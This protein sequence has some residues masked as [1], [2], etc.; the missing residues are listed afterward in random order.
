MF[1]SL[2][3]PAALVSGVIAFVL[4]VIGLMLVEF[5]LFELGAN[6]TLDILV[7]SILRFTIFGINC[8]L[9]IPALIGVVVAV[10]V[11]NHWPRRSGA[12][13]LRRAAQW[14]KDHK[15]K[16]LGP[17]IYVV[18]LPYLLVLG[19]KSL[20]ARLADVI[21][22]MEVSHDL[23]LGLLSAAYFAAALVL[24]YAG[25]VL[26]AAYN[27]GMKEVIAARGQSVPEP[28][29]GAADVYRGIFTLFDIGRSTATRAVNLFYAACNMGGGG[30]MVYVAWPIAKVTW[31]NG[32]LNADSWIAAGIAALG[33]GF[34]LYGLG[35][36]GEAL[37]FSL[38]PKPTP[39][40]GSARPA[41]EREAKAAALGKTEAPNLHDQRFPD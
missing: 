31:H 6:S 19:N 30:L 2:A 18:G 33:A 36:L 26:V 38:R 22:A 1:K 8:G 24:F 39:V 12:D 40:H 13:D 9:W 21:V 4:A 11:F 28:R 15:W 34:F 23:A 5:I 17:A 16:H 35:F 37:R 32:T 14:V 25:S 27:L 10:Y 41:E 7:S 29:L 3:A 20:N